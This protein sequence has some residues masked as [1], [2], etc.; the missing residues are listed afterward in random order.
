M[1]VYAAVFRRSFRRYSTYRAATFAGIFTNTIFGFIMAYT[2]IALWKVRPHLGGYDKS[3][4]VTYVFIGQALLITCAIFGGGFSEDFAERVRNGDIA[5]DLYRPV[6]LQ[7]WWLASD[8]GRAAFHLTGRGLPPLLIGAVV[9]RLPLP[10]NPLT[11]LAFAVSIFLGVVVSFGLRYLVALAG[12]WLLDARGLEQLAGLLAMFMSG[13]VLPLT[14]FP[15]WLGSLARNLPWSSL[16]QVPVDVLLGKADV[17]ASLRFEALWAIVVLLLGRA[18][19]AVATRRVVV[20][21][22]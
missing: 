13:M 17:L 5:I 9:F 11:W 2:Y 22:G 1:T 3:Q 21:G 16:L 4:A 6:D 8:L 14:V 15:S 20:Q 12:F 7:G 10:T 18:A 19:T